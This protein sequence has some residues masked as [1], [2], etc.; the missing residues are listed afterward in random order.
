MEIKDNKCIGCGACGAIC[1]TECITIIQNDKGFYVPGIDGEKCIDCFSCQKVC[2][3]EQESR[4]IWEPQKIYYGKHKQKN[5]IMNSSSG[6]AFSA[7]ACR[8]LERKGFVFGVEFDAKSKK[9][10]YTWVKTEQDLKALC[11]SKYVQ[12]D[13]NDV[14]K[15]VRKKLKEGIEV[16]FSGTPCSVHGLKMYLKEDYQNL[17]TIDFICHGTPSPMILED[18]LTVLNKKYKSEI[19]NIDFRPKTYGW[20]E[21][22]LKIEFSNGYVQDKKMMSD[23]FFKAFMSDNMILNDACYECSYITGHVA[24]ITL[25]DFWGYKAVMQETDDEGL[26]LVFCNTDKGLQYLEK[27]ESMTLNEIDKTELSYIFNKK[28]YGKEALARQERFFKDY[29]GEKVEKHIEK[30]TKTP[31]MI[32]LFKCFL[33]CLRNNRSK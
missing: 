26:S 20:G 17:L 14:F 16:V 18:Y 12:A 1:P 32:V 19:V 2:P 5:V 8:A 6:G 7:L 28:N 24:D 13:P 31:K 33:R 27:C 22:S 15:E 25:A 29:S 11:K 21:H 4:Y 30:H 10:R 9:A 3:M 23:S